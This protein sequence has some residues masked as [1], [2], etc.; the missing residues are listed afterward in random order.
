MVLTPPFRLRTS[1]AAA[2]ALLAVGCGVATGAP[3]DRSTYRGPAPYAGRIELP[4]DVRLGPVGGFDAATTARLEKAFADAIERTGAQ[5]MTVAVADESGMWS[6]T[7]GADGESLDRRL[8]WA[9]VGK[10]FTASVVMQLVAEGR[11]S[12]DTPI[13]AHLPDVVGADAITIDDLL[14]HTSGLFSANEAAEFRARNAYVPPADV[15]TIANEH[16]PYFRPG[17]F[18]R[19][20]N[21][22]YAALGLI[23]E[24]LEGR[25]FHEVV[26]ARVSGPSGPHALAPLESPPDLSPPAPAA[27]APFRPQPSWGYAAGNVI[28]SGEQMLRFWRRLLSTELLGEA[29][30]ARLFERCYPMGEADAAPPRTYYGRGVMVYEL[31]GPD[32]VE[33]W[34]GHSGGMPGVKAIAAWSIDRRAFAA[35]AL[36][37]DGPAQAVALLLMQQ[38]ADR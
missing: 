9:S 12:L 32:G 2:G 27:D 29:A 21:T 36:T 6:A 26:D 11:L 15:L 28:A 13:A 3:V 38:L 7:A 22:G 19:Y 23:I 25:P 16:P 1:L 17:E 31:P 34:I 20:T 8:H 14:S 30:T 35:V 5:V 33:V 24:D 4:R 10:T 18:W 37:G